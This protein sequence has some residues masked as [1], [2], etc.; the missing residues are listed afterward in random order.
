[1]ERVALA[2]HLQ[3]CQFALLAC[4]NINTMNN[5]SCDVVCRRCDL[6]QHRVICNLRIVRCPHEGCDVSECAVQI[7]RHA[8]GCVHRVV[9]CPSKDCD[10]RVQSKDLDRH[11][12]ACPWVTVQCDST[13]A[14]QR[15]ATRLLR[16][17]LA[18][19][20]GS[21][22]MA[23]VPCV[24]G[25]GIVMCRRDQPAHTCISYL[26]RCM[27]DNAAQFQVFRCCYY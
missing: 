22:S 12:L 3:R 21:C 25:C 11:L 9:S 6:A 20:V 27:M 7:D 2:T 19:H 10:V 16:K 8:D 26:S 17:D 18:V 4:P 24:G 14:D 23:V 13:F 5:V 15:C 1:M